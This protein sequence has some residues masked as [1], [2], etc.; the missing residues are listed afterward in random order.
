MHL[1]LRVPVAKCRLVA[2][3]AVREEEGE[4]LHR[5]H[6]P[7]NRRRVGHSPQPMMAPV[8]VRDGDARGASVH[9]F[10]GPDDVSRRIGVER[11]D[12]AEVAATRLQ[13]LIA[14]ILRR[15]AGVLVGED[16]AGAEFLQLDQREK[17][18]HRPH[19]TRAQPVL[20]RVRVDRRASVPP[21]DPVAQPRIQVPLS[22]GV[23]VVLRAV[24]RMLPAEFQPDDVA[25][26]PVVERR[27]LVRSD[28]IVGRRYRGRN[29]A[30]LGRII[31]NAAKRKD[32][33]HTASL[34]LSF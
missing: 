17:A 8:A 12:R 9:P 11:E 22:A 5:R 14:V 19:S 24:A 31:Q 21:E 26:M 15:G 28:H 30:H 1:P 13:E 3:V 2:M 10:Q 23:A 18:A 4:R 7:L 33:R 25:G 27:L 16:T 32:F 20:S 29:V 34:S 6:N